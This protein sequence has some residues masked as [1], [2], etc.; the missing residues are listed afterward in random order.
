VRFIGT[1]LLALDQAGGFL[2]WLDR[3]SAMRFATGSDGDSLGHRLAVST[4]RGRG[5]DYLAHERWMTQSFALAFATR[6]LA[7][8]HPSQIAGSGL[9]FTMILFI[10]H[11]IL[12]V[13]I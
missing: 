9:H 6:H 12:S 5:R 13:L 4:F 3:T 7:D 2:R 1:V 8:I 11:S 10:S